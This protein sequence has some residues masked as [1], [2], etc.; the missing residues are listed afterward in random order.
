MIIKNIGQL[1]C[2]GVKK[3]GQRSFT[4]G[5]KFP[6]RCVHGDWTM[7]GSGRLPET[8]YLEGRVIRRKCEE[9]L[10]RTISLPWLSVLIKPEPL[11]ISYPA[12]RLSKASALIFYH[13]SELLLPNGQFSC[14]AARSIVAILAMPTETRY[15]RAAAR[16]WST[17]ESIMDEILKDLGRSTVI[18]GFWTAEE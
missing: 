6:Y 13:R 16:G 15:R 9:Y 7:V 10:A 8:P 5:I 17:I 18:L 4:R 11:P 14:C 12:R 3:F 1:G 2:I